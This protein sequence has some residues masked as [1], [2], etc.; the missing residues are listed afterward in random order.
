MRENKEF[1][2][3]FLTIMAAGLV[4]IIVAVTPI[5]LTIA[6]VTALGAAIAPLAGLPDMETGRRQLH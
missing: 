4:G 6:A 1:V 5:N 2:Q 3:T